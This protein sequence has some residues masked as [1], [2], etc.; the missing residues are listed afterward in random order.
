MLMLC[1]W[2]LVTYACMIIG[3]PSKEK[4][5]WDWSCQKKKEPHDTSR[6]L[7]F[8]EP[9]ILAAT[10]PTLPFVFTA[11]CPMMCLAL[12]ASFAKIDFFICQR[13]TD[14]RYVNLQE[15]NSLP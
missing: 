4:G 10:F 1:I 14:T 3:I 9:K 7:T 12:A 13:E 11:V 15:E 5:F 2:I 8:G 6:I